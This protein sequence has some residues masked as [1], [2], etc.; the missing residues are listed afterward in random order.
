MNAMVG[1]PRKRLS[2]R[3]VAELLD[4]K[5]NTLRKWRCQGIGPKW[6]KDNGRAYYYEDDLAAYEAS[7]E[8]RED[9]NV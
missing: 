5:Q 8:H 2:T 3:A 7:K 9:Q 1:V 4:V 6:V